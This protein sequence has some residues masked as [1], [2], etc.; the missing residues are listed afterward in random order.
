LKLLPEGL[1]VAR[2]HLPLTG[3]AARVAALVFVL[4]TVGQAGEARE[5]DPGRPHVPEFGRKIYHL[6]AFPKARSRPASEEVAIARKLRVDLSRAPLIASELWRRAYRDFT[7]RIGSATFGAIL[8]DYDGTLCDGRDRFSGLRTEVSARLKQL[9]AAGVRVGIATGRGKSV[10]ESLRAALPENAWPNVLI[11]YYNCTDVGELNDD[12]HPD[13][14]T[15]PLAVLA[16][17]ENAIKQHPILSTSAIAE[18]RP[19]QLTVQPK[20]AA[21]A[22]LVWRAGLD[23]VQSFREA[24]IVRSTHSFDIIPAAASKCALLRTLG[25]LV[26]PKAVLCIGDMGRW[27]GND[28]DMLAT[29]FS[30]SVDETSLDPNSCWN[31]APSG[32]KGVQ[33]TLD[34][35]QA[36][37]CKKGTLMFAPEQVT[38]SRERE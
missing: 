37:E 26:A 12:A 19:T 4:R 15:L 3:P 14:E 24:K 33:A 13:V 6:N 7:Y 35:M 31:L 29:A 8:F 17:I 23:L 25:E 11:G 1:P 21:E 36:F 34:Y 10:R 28:R 16:A 2:I 32:H 9:V 38:T 27:P 30:L 20:A 5:I 18:L 22:D